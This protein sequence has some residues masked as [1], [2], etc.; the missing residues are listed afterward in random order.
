MLPHLLFVH[1]W[2]RWAVLLAGGL[3]CLRVF[4]RWRGAAE[5]DRSDEL[6][7]AGFGAIFTSQIL[8]GILVYVQS[9]IPEAAFAMGALF[10]KNRVVRFYTI[11]HIT[12]MVGAWL[13]FVIGAQLTYRGERE[14][15]PRR[16]VYL[17]IA[18]LVL[19]FLAIPWPGLLHGRPLYRTLTSVT[20]G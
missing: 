14:E 13:I 5:W 18:V 16:M 19:V 11:E 4:A 17:M 1:T 6:W 9:P 3:F 10:L 15:R 2:L 7:T 20:S 12:T 8:V